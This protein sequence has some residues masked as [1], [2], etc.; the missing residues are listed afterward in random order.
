MLAGN[1][2]SLIE[3][4]NTRLSQRIAILSILV[5]VAAIL[6]V[7]V[8]AARA[9]TPD[10][11][12]ASDSLYLISP[13][14]L[15]LRLDVTGK[16][17][18]TISW[19]DLDQSEAT[20]FGLGGTDGLSFGVTTSGAF[21]DKV[22][23][24]FRFSSPNSGTIG[25]SAVKN[26]VFNWQDQGDGANGNLSGVMNLSNNGGLW[27][28]GTLGSQWDQLNNGLPMTWP[29]TNI[30]A[31]DVGSG[32]FKV[33][34]F[35]RG[36]SLDSR[37]TGLYLYNGTRWDRMAP[38]VFTS[39]VLVTK[40]VV[41]PA[42]NNTFAVGTSTG[43]LY[44]TYDGAITFTQWTFELDPGAAE[45][46]GTFKVTALNWESSRLLVFMPNWGLFMSD[47]DGTTFTRSDIMVPGNL[48]DEESELVMPTIQ[49]FTVDDADDDHIVAGLLFHGAYETDDGGQSWHDLN[50]DLVVAN[51]ADPGSWSHS[52][53]DVLFDT[54][55]SQI[56][57]MGVLQKGI[58][59]TTDGGTTWLL[60]DEDIGIV[61]EDEGIQPTNRG[62]LNSFSLINRRGFSG[63]ML[64]MED[65]WSLLQSMDSG[66]TWAH[67]D[68]Q[69][70]LPTG[71]EVISRRDNSGDFMVASNGGGIYV[72]GTT[73]L[74]SD[75]FDAGTSDELLDLNL[76]LKLTF[77][78]GIVVPFDTFELI[79]Q[80]F[81]GWAVWRGAGH[82]RSQM[83]LLGL[84]DRVNPEDCFE[85][86]CGDNSLEIVPLCYRAKRAACFDLSNP[87]TVRFF[88]EEV[89]NGFSYFY[90]V[91]SFDYGNTALSS[92]QNNTNEMLFSP[93][94][95]GD[96]LS[97]FNGTGN[98]QL[99]NVNMPV[100][101]AEGG[102]EIYAY[103][104]P[105]RLGAGLPRS[106][107]ETVVFTNLPA[108]SRVRV[109][110]TAG[111]DVINL[112]PD[113][114]TGGQIYWHTNNRSGESVS[115]GIYLYKVEM[116]ARGDYWGQ[117]VV[118]R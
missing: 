53:G 73:I 14:E 113:N 110:T 88:D 51:A 50:G 85:G 83:K 106:Q 104:N 98:Q 76:G 87:D 92:P 20:C 117:I 55:D 1:V 3:E 79:A 22:D 40:I 102:D 101:A 118:I 29:R 78:G 91:T 33:A 66:A 2:I 116:P 61:E 93:R 100:T 24:L 109:F 12:C 16:P 112:G 19:P 64:A 103:P 30:V 86:Y 46:P 62:S 107:G 58:Y 26:I 115:A 25:G 108:G 96:D 5:I 23:R 52:A 75:T 68:L 63:Q 90:A 34:A 6:S 114:Q 111:D 9:Q 71:V 8:P 72:P 81:Q 97:R 10:A 44:I 54:S 65:G 38:E 49:A 31:M 56:I 27:E 57:V 94:W 7:L 15:D 59:R 67:F 32:D 105:I 74:L 39:S 45:I 95:Q 80:T 36:A 48:D 37:S 43:G 17:G 13:D 69:P 42:D 47:D 60:A 11:A 21:G 84:Y 28:Y 70:A 82:D 4:R 99:I 35:T 41:S 77:D 18:L 89:F